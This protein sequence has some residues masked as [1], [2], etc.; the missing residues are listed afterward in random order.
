M[1]FDLQNSY[2]EKRVLSF[3]LALMMHIVLFLF[4]LVGI[5]WQTEVEVP[6]EVEMWG[7]MPAT[8]ATAPPVL[9]PIIPK[10]E[11][12]EEPQDVTPLPVKPDIV[13]EKRKRKPTLKKEKEISK[14]EKNKKPLEEKKSLEKKPAPPKEKIKPAPNPLDLQ[15]IARGTVNAQQKSPSLGAGKGLSLSTS[16]DGRG[17]ELDAY[18]NQ[19]KQIIREKTIYVGEGVANPSAVL[20]VF[21]LPDGSI[22]EVK[23]L[24]VTGDP[25]FA[26][27]RRQAFLMMQK[28][29][30]LPVGMR[31]SQEREW[32]IRTRLRE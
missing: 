13:E 27:A 30:A 3:S 29:P 17:R 8:A 24:S 19:I 25:M 21:V 18:L 23:I 20:K 11:P 16:A 14:V 6:I 15:S 2:E 31:F 10:R 1:V 9:A 7:E 28:L 12:Q 5:N 4:L 22:R 26:Q 32:T